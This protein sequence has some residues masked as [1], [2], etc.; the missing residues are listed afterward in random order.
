VTD[1]DQAPAG[2]YRKA[3]EEAVNRLAGSTRS[4]GLYLTA[5]PARGV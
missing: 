5:R 1:N 3:A 2:S 4:D